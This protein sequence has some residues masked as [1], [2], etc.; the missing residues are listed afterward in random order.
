MTSQLS[1][2]EILQE[3]PVIVQVVMQAI[4]PMVI[5][6]TVTQIIIPETM[7]IVIPAITVLSSK[8]ASYEHFEK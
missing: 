2:L 7:Q 8:E 3:I 5:I 6:L 4:T 1:I